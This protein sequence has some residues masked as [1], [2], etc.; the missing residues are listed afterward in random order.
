MKARKG[1][2]KLRQ[3]GRPRK[4]G[5]QRYENG[6]IKFS[7]TNSTPEKIMA[8]VIDQREREFERLFKVKPKDAATRLARYKDSRLGYAFGKLWVFEQQ[9]EGEGISERQHEAAERW[10]SLELRHAF[11][12]RGTPPK[13]KSSSMIL[14]ARGLSC[15]TPPT[16]EQIEE[17]QRS[18]SRLRRALIDGNVGHNGNFF[19]VLTATVIDDRLPSLKDLGLLRTA[20]NCIAKEFQID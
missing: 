8:V 5:V 17:L 18:Y 7:D 11:H 2:K 1:L 10:G 16:D 14:V 20:L 6:R 19:R 4:E 9:M 15:E 12:I 3:L 13:P